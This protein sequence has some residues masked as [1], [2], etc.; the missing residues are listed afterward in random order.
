MKPGGGVVNAIV[1]NRDVQTPVSPREL[2]GGG[3]FW[4]NTAEVLVR[5]GPG[6]KKPGVGYSAAEESAE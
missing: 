1:A 6:D 4:Y 5:T 2:M 3:G